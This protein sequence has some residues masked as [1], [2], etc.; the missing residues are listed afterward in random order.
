MLSTSTPQKRILLK[1]QLSSQPCG[2]FCY[3]YLV[4]RF[5]CILP[6]FLH[7]FSRSS[8]TSKEKAASGRVWSVL[9]PNGKSPVNKGPLNLL[10]VLGLSFTF[11]QDSLP[12]EF[13][14]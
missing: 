7:G 8:E 6:F 14:N 11:I 2:I 5:L 3:I 10:I 4:Y 13:A 9:F 1:I 12:G